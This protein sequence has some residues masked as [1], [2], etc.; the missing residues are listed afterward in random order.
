MSNNPDYDGLP[1]SHAI[2][3]AL[4][5]IFWIVVCY[6]A[7]PS[8]F[9]LFIEGFS[10]EGFINILGNSTISLGCMFF[11]IYMG[12]AGVIMLFKCFKRLFFN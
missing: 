7:V 11:L 4:R 6:L 10:E 2:K 8:C 3:D 5:A 12:V 9:E 1:A